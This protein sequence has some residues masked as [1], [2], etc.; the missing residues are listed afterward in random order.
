MYSPGKH[1]QASTTKEIENSS[2]KLEFVTGR[3]DSQTPSLSGRLSLAT[4]YRVFFVDSGHRHQNYDLE[5]KTTTTKGLLAAKNNGNKLL[6]LFA[7]H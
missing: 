2:T 3:A 5:R 4:I 1:T 7:F 6:S